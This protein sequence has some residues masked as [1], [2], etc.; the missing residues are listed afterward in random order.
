MHQEFA[1]R[2][3]NWHLSI[4]CHAGHW[5]TL[6]P[7]SLFC[8]FL[9]LF[10]LIFFEFYRN[11]ILLSTMIYLVTLMFRKYCCCSYSL[12][13][14]CFY[15]CLTT[16]NHC[17]LA[18]ANPFGLSVIKRLART[19]SEASSVYFWDYLLAFTTPRWLWLQIWR[20][21]SVSTDSLTPGTLKF[22]HCLL[23]RLFFSRLDSSPDWMNHALCLWF[24]YACQ[25]WR[26]VW[27]P[28]ASHHTTAIHYEVSA[29]G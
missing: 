15:R 23:S 20:A 7:K 2:C 21:R 5:L 3:R 11:F 8:I 1:Q 29:A 12:H 17:L 27:S 10:A 19:S 22:C 25:S 26:I 4:R 24:V 13:E 16:E 6:R 18:P 14:G 9:T 28:T